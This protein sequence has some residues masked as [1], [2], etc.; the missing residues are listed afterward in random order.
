MNAWHLAGILGAAAFAA[1]VPQ[2]CAAG[3]EPNAP[4]GSGGAGVTS[5]GPGTPTS[6]SGIGP[7]SSTSTFATSGGGAASSAVAS[8][9]AVTTVASTAASTAAS[10]SAASTAA[11]ST[12]AASTAAASTSA[13]STAASTAASS[14]SASSSG[15]SSG[16]VSCT[17]GYCNTGDG[18]YAF[19]YSDSQNVM[20][21]MPGPSTAT[22]ESNGSLCISGDVGQIVNMDYTDDWGC[23]VGVNLN[24]AMGMNTPKN[25]FT[26]T[27]SGVTVF[28]SAVPSCT[29][30][31]VII[32]QNGTDY[33]APLTPGVQI[34]WGSFNTACWNNSGPFLS[35]PPSSQSL[36]VQFV[37]STSQSCAFTNFCITE[38]DF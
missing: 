13:A 28:T 3:V 8:S 12:S 1:A 26:P 18:G 31:R 5:V 36:K 4:P 21:Q 24:Q 30:A 22:L 20:P 16:P 9:A 7:A 33:C 32:D 27:G 19:A 35:G 23:G 6:S 17:M 11:A 38:I 34:P 14:T 29:T 15:S 25:T 2:G 10:T 37:A